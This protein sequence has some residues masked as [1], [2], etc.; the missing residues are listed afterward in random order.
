MEGA[1]GISS[2][3]LPILLSSHYLARRLLKSLSVKQGLKYDSPASAIDIPAFI[4]FHGLNIDEIR[5]PI[6]SFKTFNQFFYRKLVPDARPVA[7]PHD[8]GRLVSCA[9]CRMMAFET[10]NAATSIWIKGREFSVARLLGPAYKD[11]AERFEGGGL[12]IF[13]SIGS[14]TI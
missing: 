4:A 1:R 14:F 6:E 10:V 12:G 5:D 8:P 13:R 11:V 7:D 3:I 9:D 2:R